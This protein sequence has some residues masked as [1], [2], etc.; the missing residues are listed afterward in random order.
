VAN[1]FTDQGGEGYARTTIDIFY[2]VNARAELA[3]RQRLK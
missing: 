2:S 3:A 1:N